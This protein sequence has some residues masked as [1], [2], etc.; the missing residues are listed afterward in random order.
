MTS[1][2]VGLTLF[3]A[4]SLVGITARYFEMLTRMEIA[5]GYV[6]LFFVSIFVRFVSVAQLLFNLVR[7]RP[8]NCFFSVNHFLF[9]FFFQTNFNS[10]IFLFRQ[11]FCANPFFLLADGL[12]RA[13]RQLQRI[14]TGGEAEI[15]DVDS[16]VGVAV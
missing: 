16:V 3:Y 9:S 10:V 8:S 12:G 2:A 1:S 7:D 5:V 13:N 14:G 6:L 4:V 15:G 11:I